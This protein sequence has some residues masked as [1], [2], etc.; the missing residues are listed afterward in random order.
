MHVHLELSVSHQISTKIENARAS[1]LFAMRTESFK[2][3][4][5]VPTKHIVMTMSSDNR[6]RIHCHQKCS[7]NKA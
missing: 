4:V 6:A 7:Q 1:V 3:K 5:S 2:K